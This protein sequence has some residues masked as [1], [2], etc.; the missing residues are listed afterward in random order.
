MKGMLTFVLEQ[1]FQRWLG[2]GIILPTG[3]E[4]EMFILTDPI[5]IFTHLQQ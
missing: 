4:T 1:L 5:I 2:F 3:K